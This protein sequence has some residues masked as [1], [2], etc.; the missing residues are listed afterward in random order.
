MRLALNLFALGALVLGGCATRSGPPSNRL[1]AQGDRLLVEVVG[2]GNIEIGQGRLC[3]S[4]QRCRVDWQQV[5]DPALSASAEPGWRLERWELPDSNATPSNFGDPDQR[6]TYRAVF[7]PERQVAA[8][9]SHRA[10]Q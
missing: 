2:G 3:S 7:V 9:Q 8:R 1:I 6:R 10:T 4:G 5:A